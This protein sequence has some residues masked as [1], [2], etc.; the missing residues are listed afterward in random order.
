MNLYDGYITC[1]LRGIIVALSMV[2]I[3]CAQTE[4]EPSA[5]SS[6]WASPVEAVRPAVEQVIGM[7]VTFEINAL[8]RNEEWAY[9]IAVPRTESGA[10]IDYT[11]TAFAEDVREGYFDDWLCAL[12]R[13]GSYGKWHLVAMSI[14]ATDAPFMDWPERY[15]VPR[16]LVIPD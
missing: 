4:K 13:K 10:A 11:D 2:L 9:L 12:V 8:R 1:L 14:G 6:G 3:G 16:Q 7:P 15:G 5:A